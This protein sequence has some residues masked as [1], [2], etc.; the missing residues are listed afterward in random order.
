MINS[1]TN[2][3]DG[4]NYYDI[5]KDKCMY[6]YCRVS[7]KYQDDNGVSLEVQRDRGLEVSKRL[8]LE[9]IVIMEQGSGLKL[10]KNERPKFSKLMEGVED[11]MVENIWIDELTRKTRNDVDLPYI[12]LEMKKNGINLYVG[13][14]GKIN[15]W[16]FETKVL[17]TLITMVNQNQIEKQVRKSIRSKRRLFQEGCYMKGDPPFGYE[18]VDKKLVIN[19]EESE[20][21]KNMFEWY[22]NGT[23]TWVIQSELFTN[24]IFVVKN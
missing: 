12:Q 13:S 23:S 9:P 21:V 22:N 1:V 8:G 11:G 20:W 16:G 14:E 18:L 4:F 15:E 6:I 10:Y 5:P 7:T 24:G 19:Q 17:D 2:G 3:T